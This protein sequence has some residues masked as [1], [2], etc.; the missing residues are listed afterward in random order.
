M[1]V[2]KLIILASKLFMH[3]NEPGDAVCQLDV[4]RFNSS[5]AKLS[6]AEHTTLPPDVLLPHLS[7][8]GN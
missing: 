2:L 1:H 8:S 7:Y 5:N 4:T 6:K 3:N